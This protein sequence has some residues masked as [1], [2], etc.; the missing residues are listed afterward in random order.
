MLVFPALHISASERTISRATLVATLWNIANNP[1][2]VGDYGFTDVA[3]G[4]WY[5]EPITWAAENNLVGGIGGGLFAPNDPMTREQAATLL[6]RYKQYLG[7]E[8][9]GTGAVSENVPDTADVSR[10]AREAVTFALVWGILTEKPG[11]QIDPKGLVTITEAQEMLDRLMELIRPDV[12]DIPDVFPVSF[13]IS[14]PETL[15]GFAMPKGLAVDN[16][17]NLI[18]FDTYNASIVRVENNDKK[19]IAGF[20]A[21]LDEFGFVMPFFRDGPVENALLGRPAGGV[22][23]PSGDIFFADRDN[24]RL[25]R[26]DDI[27][28]IA[29][30]FNNPS[31]IVID[32]NNNLY[33]ADTL[34]H[35]IQKITPDGAVTTVAGIKGTHGYRNGYAGT[36]LLNEPT[37]LAIGDD[38]A[39]YIADTGNHLIRRLYN[40][41]I[42]TAAGTYVA[43]GVGEYYGPG[44]F[45]NGPAE[46]A[47]FRFPTGLYW[48]HGMLF[49]ADS[50][51]HAIR[52]LADN[53]VTT[54]VGN[55]E[56]G[57]VLH[58]PLSV[59]YADG[60]LYIADTLNNRV[61]ALALEMKGR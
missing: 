4:A 36:A 13:E 44:G 45:V 3:Q 35:T 19:A 42:T 38:G 48:A 55:G 28:T 34:N 37:G 47:S 25:L 52:A 46:S 15:T 29:T 5:Y 2:S 51:N 59:L 17:G 32:E 41:V 50:G 16:D 58:H 10:W 53:A 11:G 22:A 49:I 60:V 40:G 39:L 7:V 8:P 54:V 12:P 27:Y 26:G 6:Y 43:P 23:A 9:Q 57:D 56:P 61:K 20:P 31:A 14:I 30:G 21:A 24:I 18:V 33:V 1:A